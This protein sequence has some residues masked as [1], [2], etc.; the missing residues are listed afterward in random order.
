M[1]RRSRAT[2]GSSSRP[3]P[4]SPASPTAGKSGTAE[5]GG[6]GEPHSWFI[7]FAPVENPKIAIA[8]L[9]ER[10]GRGGERAAP[11]AGDLMARY[12]DLY[13]TRGRDPEAADRPA[14]AA[15]IAAPRGRGRGRRPTAGRSPTAGRARSSSGIGLAVI[16]LVLAALFAVVAVA[17]FVGGEPF[18]GVMGAIGC[19]MVL[20]VGGLTLF[21]G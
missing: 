20:W 2:S 19:L 6:K 4:R 5:L 8:V 11:L 16:A 18:L 7:G 10:G 17:A 13:G 21:R 3:A 1:Q 14:T 15:P 12:F 9:V